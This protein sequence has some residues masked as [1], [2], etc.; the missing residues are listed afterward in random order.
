MITENIAS[1]KPVVSKGRELILVVTSSGQ[2]VWVNK[3]QFDATSETVSY[4]SHKAGSTY[5][6]KATGVEGQ[7]KS[8]M[9]EFVG[10]GKASKFAVIDYLVSKGIT[11]TFSLS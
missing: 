10:C 7:R 9:N 6:N 11:P 4:L 5:M 1:T 3:G 8:D 2:Q